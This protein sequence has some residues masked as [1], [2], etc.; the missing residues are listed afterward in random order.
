LAVSAPVE[1]FTAPARAAPSL[2]EPSRSSL[3]LASQLTCIGTPLVLGVCGGRGRLRPRRRRDEIGSPE[4]EGGVDFVQA[5][6]PVARAD[7]GHA[8]V[9]THKRRQTW[10]SPRPMRRADAQ[11]LAE[12]C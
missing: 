12:M 5:Y 6:A 4:F 9:S 1:S 7:P 11:G 3:L 10:R 2:V 8:A